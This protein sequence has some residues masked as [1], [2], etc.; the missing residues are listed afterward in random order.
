MSCTILTFRNDVLVALLEN[1][2]KNKTD[3]V[4]FS[5]AKQEF[6]TQST[7]L[8][9]FTRQCKLVCLSM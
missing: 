7:G 2:D 9:S 6:Y 8:V 1:E 5:E 4:V 3:F